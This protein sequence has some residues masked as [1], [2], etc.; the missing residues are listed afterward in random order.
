MLK[1]STSA[2]EIKGIGSDVNIILNDDADFSEIE[3][4]LTKKLR[5]SKKFFSGINVIL[6]TRGR[7][8][9]SDEVESLRKI[10]NERFNLKVS[11]VR[12][13]SNETR[14]IFKRIGWETEILADP[15][16]ENKILNEAKN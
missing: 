6:D 7:I 2:V 5:N 9:G 3:S 10:L 12:S 11:F 13:Q 15:E 16:E 1:K 14:E 4:E 8:L